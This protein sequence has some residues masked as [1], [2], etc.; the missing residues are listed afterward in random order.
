MA[1][2]I[3]IYGHNPKTCIG[4]ANIQSNYLLKNLLNMIR[5]LNEEIVVLQRWNVAEWLTATIWKE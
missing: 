5:K 3:E 1:I 2:K 4:N